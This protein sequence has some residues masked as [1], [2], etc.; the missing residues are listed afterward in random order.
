[1]VQMILNIVLFIR[2][3][4]HYL[5]CSKSTIGETIMNGEKLKLPLFITFEDETD[6]ENFKPLEQYE[7]YFRLMTEEGIPFGDIFYL[8]VN[9]EN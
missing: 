3:G 2:F 1:M 6:D 9:I 8:Q 5:G 4:K 7:G